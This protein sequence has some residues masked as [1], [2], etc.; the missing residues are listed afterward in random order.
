M[1]L[2]KMME[3]TAARHGL[4][5]RLVEAV[6]KV[7]S[8]GDPWAFRYEPRFYERYVL[9]D[10]SLRAAPPCSLATERQARASSWGLMQ[11]M[12]ATARG[13]GFSGPFLA[14]LCEPSAGLEYGCRLLA[15]LRDRHLPSLGWPGVVAA[16][17]AGSPRRDESGR[18]VNQPYVEKIAKALQGEWPR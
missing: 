3:E 5:A 10:A 11:V 6:V 14:Q 17:N 9:N 8:G 12:G 4:P 2:R 15:L 1:E 13:L 7:E 16:Y 18:Y